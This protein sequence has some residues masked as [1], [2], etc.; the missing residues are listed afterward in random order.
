MYTM[1]TQNKATPRFRRK[2]VESLSPNQ[3]RDTVI[4]TIRKYYEDASKLANGNPA[5]KLTRLGNQIIEFLDN[6]YTEGE[7]S[8][9]TYSKYV[10][11]IKDA[12]RSEFAFIN[13]EKAVNDF[14]TKKAIKNSAFYNLLESAPFDNSKNHDNWSRDTKKA[15]REI[16]ASDPKLKK[17]ADNLVKLGGELDKLRQIIEPTIVSKLLQIESAKA[18]RVNQYKSRKIAREEGKLGFY[19]DSS[20]LIKSALKFLNSDSEATAFIPVGIDE[21]GNE[22]KKDADY[23]YQNGWMAVALAI[24]LATGRRT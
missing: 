11:E 2:S 8:A 19:Y 5:G 20:P 15:I 13:S 14:L 1:K 9:N 12:I 24:M 7:I 23:N 17:D 3:M 22:Y 4:E 16:A 18:D 10:S 6:R 21:E